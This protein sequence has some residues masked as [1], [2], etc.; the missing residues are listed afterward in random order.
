MINNV[1]T[2]NTGGYLYANQSGSH[3]Y[4]SPNSNNPMQGMVRLNGGTLEVFDGSSWIMITSYAEIHLSSTAISALDWANRKMIE[5][6]KFRSLA[7]KSVAV[8]DALAT[9]E[10]AR[11]QLNVVMTL[12]DEK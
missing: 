6:A 8:A 12:A 9:Y 2:G 10:K 3:P 4:V 5:E 1:N 11:E 7:D